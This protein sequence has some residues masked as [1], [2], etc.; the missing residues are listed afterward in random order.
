MKRQT[1]NHIIS[2]FSD[3]EKLKQQY[4]SHSNYNLLLLDDFLTK[5]IAMLMSTE[6]DSVPLNKCK[7]FTRANSCMYECNDLDITPVQSFVVQS[8][9]SSSFI[10]WLESVTGLKRLIP[11]PHLIGAG[12]AKSFQGD[13]LKIHS[14]FNWNEQLGLHRMVSVVIYLNDDWQEEWGGQLNFYDTNRKNIIQKVP[15]KMGN[16]VIWEYNNL[17]FHGYPEPM[18][19]PEN[20]SR[21]CF[22]LFYYVSNAKHNVDDPPHRSLYWFDD[23][24]GK[25]YDIKSEK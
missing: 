9:H 2:N 8:L 10:R 22:R 5:D 25:P 12:Y 13:S 24:E 23:K 17:A 16:C 6:L 1:I 3:V 4:Q 11:D 18:T 7:H 14:D 21:K 19:C 20:Y 15:I